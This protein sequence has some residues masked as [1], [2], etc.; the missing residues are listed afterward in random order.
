MRTHRPTL[1]VLGSGFLVL[2]PY[3]LAPTPDNLPLIEWTP[4]QSTSIK[5]RTPTSF[6]P[7]GAPPALSFSDHRRRENAKIQMAIKRPAADYELRTVRCALDC[8]LTPQGAR[9]GGR[10]RA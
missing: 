4:K 1:L 5:R 2:G 10:D 3:N 9:A 8:G 6:T 7:A